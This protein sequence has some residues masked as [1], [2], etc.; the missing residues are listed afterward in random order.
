MPAMPNKE[1]G[2]RFIGRHS[3]R[4][5]APVHLCGTDAS[6][7]WHRDHDIAIDDLDPLA[8]RAA[9]ALERD[10]IH[11]RRQRADRN[12]PRRQEHAIGC[13]IEPLVDGPAIAIR[14]ADNQLFSRWPRDVDDGAVARR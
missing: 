5:A 4:W 9:F 10:Q 2:Y 11:P 7:S 1:R 14:D 13:A 3:T 8:Q 12:S 6:S